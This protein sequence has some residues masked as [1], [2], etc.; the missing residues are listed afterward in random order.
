MDQHARGAITADAFRADAT[1]ILDDVRAG[2]PGFLAIWI[3]DDAGSTVASSGRNDLVALFA[4][5]GSNRIVADREIRAGRA[6]AAGR[7]RLCRCL[8][9]PRSDP[10]PGR[11]W[12]RIFLVIDLSDIM[13]ASLRLSMARRDGR[14]PGRGPDR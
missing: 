12:G 14:V 11:R 2:S 6:A 10:D 7:R 13:A 9:V 3:E 8:P 4:A 1:R 5:S